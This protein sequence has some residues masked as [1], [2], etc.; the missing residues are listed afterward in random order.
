M[1]ICPNCGF[2][3]PQC[4]RQNRWV[5]HVD[6][7][8]VEDFFEQYPQFANMQPGEERSDMYSYYYRGKKNPY[9]VYRWPKFLGPSYYTKTR[10]LTEKHIPR[11]PPVKGQK[12]LLIV[13]KA[14]QTG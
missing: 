9:F 7:T 5:S 10:H 3:D 13:E 6:Y 4:W 8:R 2:I 1:R 14:G 11:R 12:T